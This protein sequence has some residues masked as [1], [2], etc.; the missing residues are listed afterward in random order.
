MPVRPS[1]RL[2][3]AVSLP[4]LHSLS[5]FLSF[6]LSPSVFVVDIR[7][8]QRLRVADRISADAA[9]EADGTT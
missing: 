2:M 7:T 6:A 4:Q 5:F 1:A 9:T 8:R 3:G